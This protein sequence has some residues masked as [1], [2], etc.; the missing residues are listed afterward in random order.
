MADIVDVANDLV[1]LSTQQ[2]LTNILSRNKPVAELND[3]GDKVCLDCADIIPVKRA[4]SH[5]V[6]RCIE[7]QIIEENPIWQR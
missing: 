2:A 4:A 7:C 1:D 6:V 5:G 3:N